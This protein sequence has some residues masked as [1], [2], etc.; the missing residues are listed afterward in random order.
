MIV[1]FIEAI[2]LVSSKQNSKQN[3]VNRAKHTN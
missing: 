1:N 3:E 2:L